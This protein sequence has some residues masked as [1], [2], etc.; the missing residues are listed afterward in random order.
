MPSPT[1]AL[2]ESTIDKVL[3]DYHKSHEKLCSETVLRMSTQLLK[4][5]KFIHSAGMCH[6]DISGRNI[7]FSCTHL[8]KQT[9]EQLFD[10][11]GFPE[12]EP[13][14]REPKKLA[15]LGSLRVLETIFTDS[16]DY[17]VDLWR[18]GSMIYSFLFTIWPFWYLGEDEVLIFQMIGFVERL[19]AE[20]ESKWTSMLMRSSHDL[21]LE[22]DYGTSKLER[23]FAG[24]VPNLT[25]KP[26][27][28]VIQGLMRFL[29]SSR[30]T[31]EDALDLLGNAQ[32]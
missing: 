6:G 7:A 2:T 31:A 21:E 1:K 29:P 24:L 23:K 4:A 19:P 27:L 28:H 13:L 16:F 22:E 3:A 10:V 14:T 30:L 11:L 12:V 5:V 20:W 32:E 18:I 17:R 15:Q 9:E 25:L 8:W 26:L